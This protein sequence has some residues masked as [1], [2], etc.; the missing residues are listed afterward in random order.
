MPHPV[1][2]RVL[3]E[4]TH[5]Q[6]KLILCDLTANLMAVSCPWGHN[7][8]HLG[9]L[10]DPLL[11][12]AQNGAS[13]DVPA[14][15]P[16]LYPV[17]P[18]GATTHQCKELW[19]QNT[20]TP[21]AWTTYHLLRAITRNQFAAAIDDIFYAVLGNPIEGLN[22]IDLRTLVQHIAT[23]YAQISQPDLYN[24]LA[25]LNTGIE[26]GLPL[27]VYTR[28]QECCQVFALNAAVP[29]SE[30]T[31]VTTGT[32]HALSCSNMIMAWREWNRCAIANHTWP[33]WKTH[34]MS[35]FAEMHGINRMMAGEAA[36]GINAAEEE[37]QA[38]QITALLDNL[39][40]MS[41]QK[42]ATIN[43]LVAS[44]AQLMQ[45]LQEMQAAMVHMFPASQTHYS[46]YQPPMWVPTPPE[47]TAP[48]TAS[49]AP[50]L[51]MMGPRLSHWGSVK[52]AWDKQGYCWSHGHK[53]KVGHTCTTCS[54]WHAGHRPGAT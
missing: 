49:P 52:P 44:N 1:P 51:A 45:A 48:P 18:A 33:N 12:L 5:K 41:I 36:F 24:N 34:W 14:A 31:M 29:I 50:P 20:S 25:N 39:A 40:N 2:I 22:G 6:L 4:P 28:K 17:V 35:V 19:A 30:A 23:T 11:Y 46:P 21:K 15:E 9:L 10:Q 32:K 37:Q 38:C 7:K 42:N 3:R 16:F 13:F 43:N 54:S 26:P 47:A 27:A 8:G 53:V